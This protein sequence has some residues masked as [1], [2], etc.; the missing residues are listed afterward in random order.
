M[1]E[2][3]ISYILLAP[4]ISAWQ[5]EGKILYVTEGVTMRGWGEPWS[6]G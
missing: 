6:E 5:K 4:I 1:F 3:K 2:I